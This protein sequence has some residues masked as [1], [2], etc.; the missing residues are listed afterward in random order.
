MTDKRKTVQHFGLYIKIFIHIVRLI[1]Y[2]CHTSI[3]NIHIK[4]VNDH[5]C[6]ENTYEWTMN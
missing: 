1:K 4:Y 5:N 3:M 6:L 2:K